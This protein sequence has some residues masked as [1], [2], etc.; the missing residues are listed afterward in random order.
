MPK[1]R[2]AEIL[3]RNRDN[4]DPRLAGKTVEGLKYLG[5]GPGSHAQAET[6]RQG[7][8]EDGAVFAVALVYAHLFYAESGGN[9]SRRGLR[10]G[11]RLRHS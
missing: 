5:V 6:A 8:A 3:K 4:A 2:P 1:G 11:M 7:Y 9:E 10:R